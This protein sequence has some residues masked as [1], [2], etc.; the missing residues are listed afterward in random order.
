MKKL[1]LLI[2][3]CMLISIGG[4]YATWTYLDKTDVADETVNM[5]MNLTSV[6]YS[7]SYGTYTVDASAVKLTIDPKTGTTHTT[8]LTIEGFIKITFKPNQ[9]APESI[10]NSAVPSTFKFGLTN[11]EWKFKDQNILTL[12]HSEAE[13][14]TWTKEGDVF[15]FTLSAADMAEHLRLTEITLDTKAEYDAYSVVLGQGQISIT[16]SDGK[17]ANE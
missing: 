1:S 6:A 16:V 3:L 9:Y 5:A 11:S 2:A 10:K 7:S 14:I 4:V 15:T 12:V 13:Q 17:T 8:A